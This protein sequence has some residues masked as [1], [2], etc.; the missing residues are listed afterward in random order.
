[1]NFVQAIYD[2]NKQAGLLEKR[3]K[4]LSKANT[5]GARGV[6]FRKSENKY[7]TYFNYKGKRYRPGL[8]STIEEAVGSLIIMQKEVLENE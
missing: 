1:M 5:S 4:R 7:E 8:Y 6:S 3:Y 2:F